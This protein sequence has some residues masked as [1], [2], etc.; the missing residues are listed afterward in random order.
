MRRPTKPPAFER[1]PTGSV[2][3]ARGRSIL[4]EKPLSSCGPCRSRVDGQRNVL[5][6][7]YMPVVRSVSIP[8]ARERLRAVHGPIEIP[9]RAPF[10]RLSSSTP[11]K[12]RGGG[13]MPRAVETSVVQGGR[14]RLRAFRPLLVWFCLAASLLAW[15]AYRK[16]AAGTAVTCRILRAGSHPAAVGGSGSLAPL[17][18]AGFPGRSRRHERLSTL[19]LFFAH[20]CGSH[21]NFAQ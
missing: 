1:C 16:L 7:D 11:N 14:G 10:G 21:L 9:N 5:A 13:V 19:S 8:P 18:R 17:P 6:S 20:L 12:S 3:S 15:D 4:R 2:S